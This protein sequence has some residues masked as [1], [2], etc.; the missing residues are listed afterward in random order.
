MPAVFSNAENS[1]LNQYWYSQHTIET[2][3]KE[4]QLHG[5]RVAFLSTPS[6][7]FSLTDPAVI[8]EAVLFE[9]D[10]DFAAQIEAKFASSDNNSDNNKSTA[11]SRTRFVHYDYNEPERVPMQFMGHFDYVVVDPPFITEEVW[12]KYAQTVKFIL[13]TGTGPNASVN[14]GSG[15]VMFTSVLENH[16]MLETVNDLPLYIADFMPSIPNLVY[17]YYVFV[18]YPATSANLGVRN[19]KEI[20]YGQTEEEKK[21]LSAIQM[22]NDLRESEVA[23]T[24]QMR[25]RDRSDEVPLPQPKPRQYVKADGSMA[26][27]VKSCATDFNHL[28]NKNLPGYNPNMNELM[29]KPIEEMRWSHVPAGLTEYAGGADAPPAA[30]GPEVTYFG[31][32]HANAVATRALLEEFKKGV[33]TMQKLLD[34]LIRSDAKLASPAIAADEAAAAAVKAERAEAE[35][36]REALLVTMGELK[37]KAEANGEEPLVTNVMAQC[38]AAYTKVVIAKEP[39]QELAGDATRLFKSPIFNRQKVLL[40]D[41]KKYKQEFLAEQKKAKETA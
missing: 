12:R 16:N 39:A 26:D 10:T 28:K 4:I 29:D 30:D 35:A 38:V 22:A 2:L 37:E 1:G 20:P 15:K 17:Q 31:E 9:F 32:K 21:V 6:L 8:E 34:V 11:S 14:G 13:N 24:L 23:F 36:S 33:D 41:I 27:K 40:A 7:Y 19:A 18:N 5:Q 3:V 25:N